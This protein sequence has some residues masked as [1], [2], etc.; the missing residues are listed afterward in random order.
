MA[1]TNNNQTINQNLV[2]AQAAQLT[3]IYSKV[4]TINGLLSG[5]GGIT[6]DVLDVIIAK[7][8]I[9]FG[10]MPGALLDSFMKS[11]G[12][13]GDTNEGAL[14]VALSHGTHADGEVI[15]LSN[16]VVSGLLGAVLK[17]VALII[18]GDSKS[19]RFRSVATT[20]TNRFIC[21]QLG[22]TDCSLHYM[23]KTTTRA[24]AESVN[25]VPTPVAFGMSYYKAKAGIS[26]DALT[27]TGGS[28]DISTVVKG[29]HATLLGAQILAYAAALASASVAEPDANLK[30]GLLELH[31]NASANCTSEAVAT[32]MLETYGAAVFA[33]SGVTM[34]IV[35]S[36]FPNIG[37]SHA[38]YLNDAWVTKAFADML[39]RQHVI[40]FETTDRPIN[41]LLADNYAIAAGT[42]KWDTTRLFAIIDNAFSAMVTL[43]SLN[44]ETPTKFANAI[45]ANMYQATVIN[46]L[47]HSGGG[48]TNDVGG[49]MVAAGLSLKTATD[50]ATTAD[51]LG[52]FDYTLVLP[53][54]SGNLASTL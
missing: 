29:T 11:S 54:V 18:W 25:G 47:T 50:A 28:F 52:L 51:V 41:L 17:T 2:A 46:A 20:D 24:L 33:A 15:E 22:F 1:T 43:D 4:S 36:N 3:D 42:G 27:W 13:A 10:Y 44:I 31:L 19:A 34:S 23:S 14:V 16:Q 38:L 39:P 53:N 45:T 32:I 48:G 26:T 37:K 7:G 8:Y 6:S 40:F 21:N 35:E 12:A 49:K 5:V 30:A 9:T